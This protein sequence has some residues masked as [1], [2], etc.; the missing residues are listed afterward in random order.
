LTL[1][2]EQGCGPG[3]AA[4][5]YLQSEELHASHQ[6]LPEE[7]SFH[8]SLATSLVLEKRILPA[9]HGLGLFLWI[10]LPLLSYKHLKTKQNKTKQLLPELK[11]VIF[12]LNYS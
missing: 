8:P 5:S 12:A 3:S 7:L 11:A 10:L 6:G 9:R 1:G 2:H 4:F